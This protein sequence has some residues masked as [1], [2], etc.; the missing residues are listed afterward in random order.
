MATLSIQPNADEFTKMWK[1]LWSARDIAWHL[2]KRNPTLVK[3]EHLLME[4]RDKMTILFPFCGKVIDMAHYYKDGHT[5]FGVECSKDGIMDFFKEQGLEYEEIQM[6]NGKD[7]YYATKDKRL[8]ILNTNFYTLDD[9]LINGRINAV[10]DRGAFGTVTEV[11]QEL[12][13]KTMKKLLA[14]DFRY[15][16]L[17]T[18]YDQS[19]WDGVPFSQPEE[20]VK[21]FYDWANIEKLFSWTPEHVKLYQ[22]HMNNPMEVK[23]TTYLMTAKK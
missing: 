9:E 8:I 16:L 10:W 13:I 12:Y 2:S 6:S 20:K 17:V 19:K 14:A 1:E 15:L 5:V 23:E 3:Y 4:G 22:K 21:R 7:F 11:E 18:E